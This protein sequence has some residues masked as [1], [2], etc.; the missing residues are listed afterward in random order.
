MP[1]TRAIA[2]QKLHKKV[3]TAEL[4]CLAIATSCS[5]T[6]SAYVVF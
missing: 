1:V 2:I 5:F 6:V 3:S 4:D